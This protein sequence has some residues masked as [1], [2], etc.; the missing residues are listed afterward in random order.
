M[1]KNGYNEVN[2]RE[3]FN[4]VGTRY[5]K[6]YGHN[7]KHIAVLEYLCR[8]LP[9]DSHILDVGCGTG[10]PTAHFLS[11][12]GHRVVGIDISH[13]MVEISRQNVPN[14]TF[15]EVDMT[16]YTP[17]KSLNAVCAFYALFQ[18]PAR[19]VKAQINRF[20][21]WIEP[22]GFLALST[23]PWGAFDE[24]VESPE[25]DPEIEEHGVPFM[26]MNQL[27]RQTTFRREK[28]R[29]M[30]A[31]NGFDILKC[32]EFQFKPDDEE[33]PY[34]DRQYWIIARRNSLIAPFAPHTSQTHKAQYSKFGKDCTENQISRYLRYNDP[35]KIKIFLNQFQHKTVSTLSSPGFEEVLNL[36]L[37]NEARPTVAGKGDSSM[38]SFWGSDCESLKQFVNN[39]S[40]DD[41]KSS[42]IAVIQGAPYNELLDL[43]HA[44]CSPLLDTENLPAH[45][46]HI[47]EIA[48]NTLKD[49][50]YRD[51]TFHPI[52]ASFDFSSEGKYA[53]NVAANFF[54]GWL[55]PDHKNTVALK[56]ALENRI[57]IY[58]VTRSN[59]IGFNLIAL[60]AKKNEHI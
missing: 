53:A 2:V 32:D 52:E 33:T 16:K 42:H 27:Q 55:Y 45:Q 46:G 28:W 3:L 54:V 11:S 12:Q 30:L 59:M 15:H 23:V 47:L 41:Q 5:E 51:V 43:I 31:E 37:H 17:L 34:A 13:R 10:R 60:V 38:L 14:A 1:M 24:Y 48:A 50:N 22:G 56:E 20:A 40:K 4:T 58:F 25:N 21:S 6:A 57:K 44:V 39:P 29:E 35:E 36:L 9:P 49:S 8:L 26:W 18:L 7:P 19:M